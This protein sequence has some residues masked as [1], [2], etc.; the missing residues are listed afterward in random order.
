[1]MNWS[2]KNALRSVFLWLTNNEEHTPQ[3]GA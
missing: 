3:H 2:I 1:L